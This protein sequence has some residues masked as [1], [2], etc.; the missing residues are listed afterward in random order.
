MPN[1]FTQRGAAGGDGDSPSESRLMLLL[2]WPGSLVGVSWTAAHVTVLMRE[3]LGA[4]LRDLSIEQPRGARE[5]VGDCGE[6]PRI[7]IG[8]HRRELVMET[9][10]DG[11]D[12]Q[13]AVRD[14][15]SI[16]LRPSRGSAARRTKPPRSIRA[17]TPVMAPVVSW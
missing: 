11:V 10:K 9:P 16:C 7:V 5:T 6:L 13:P 12:I 2:R 15:V 4:E 8:D 1:A 3:V 14:W 17:T